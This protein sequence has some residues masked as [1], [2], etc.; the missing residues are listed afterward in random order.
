MSIAALQVPPWVAVLVLAFGG[1]FAV[2]GV[3]TLRAGR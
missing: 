2:L 3:L 1:V